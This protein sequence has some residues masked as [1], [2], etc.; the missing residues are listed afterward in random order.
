MIKNWLK[1][2]NSIKD[3][4]HTFSAVSLKQLKELDSSQDKRNVEDAEF[5]K[6]VM[7]TREGNLGAKDMKLIKNS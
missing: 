7:T 2:E 1:K 5:V 3:S 6:N 4:I